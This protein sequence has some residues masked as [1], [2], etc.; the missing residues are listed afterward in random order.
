MW[1]FALQP[2][3][4]RKSSLTFNKDAIQSAI[5]R[6]SDRKACGLSKTAEDNA[7]VERQA[8]FRKMTKE[9][10]IARLHEFD[11]EN[12]ALTKELIAMLPELRYLRDGVRDDWKPSIQWFVPSEEE[13]VSFKNLLEEKII[14][15]DEIANKYK[16][17]L[18][19][20]PTIL[21]EI[22]S[23]LTWVPA[24]INFG[25]RVDA[26]KWDI[27]NALQDSNFREVLN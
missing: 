5:F 13:Y 25:K 9:E 19:T 3:I 7:T 20:K 26:G 2:S 11:I 23:Q 24:P 1:P 8:G 18:R 17:Y 21:K 15:A 22:W 6:F 27:I 10:T 12:E 14:K 16:Y 4:E